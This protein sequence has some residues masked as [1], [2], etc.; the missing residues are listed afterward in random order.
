MTLM[1]VFF[2]IAIGVSFLCSILEAAL[3]STTHQFIQMYKEKNEKTGLLLEKHKNQIDVP[4]AAILTLNTIAHTLGAAGVGAQ[5]AKIFGDEWQVAISVILTL[6]IL[7]LSEIIPKTIGATHWK[8]LAGPGAYVISFLITITYPLVWSSLFITKALSKNKQ[9][10]LVTRE[11]ILALTELGE[12]SGSL[13]E[14]ESELIENLL[15]LKDIKAKDIC[16]PRSVVFA[17]EEHISVVEAVEVDEVY[18]HSRIPV[19]HDSMDNITGLVFNQRI[20][21]ESVDEHHDKKLSEISVPIFRISE[22]LPV[23]NLFDLFV[24]RKEHMF[25]VTDSYGQTVGIVTL[26]DAIETLLGVEIV[27]ELDKFEDMQVVAKEKA[28]RMR[29]KIKTN[30]DIMNERNREADSQ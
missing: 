13:R 22:N 12:K 17:L 21:E 15:S 2:I 10:D 29:S 24:K 1:I 14:K 23:L 11:E 18:T 26:E 4:I 5:A 19:Y 30:D 20:L 9:K 3:L 7:Y 25:L 8:T 6:A 28:K 27:D 16:T